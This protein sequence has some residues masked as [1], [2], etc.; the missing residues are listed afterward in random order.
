MEEE[1]FQSQRYRKSLKQKF[2][3]EGFDGFADEEVLELMLIYSI[4][5]C[6]IRPLAKSLLRVFGDFMGVLDAPMKELVAFP[7]MD[8]HTAIMLKAA[9][10]FP[11]FYS[12]VLEKERV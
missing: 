11:E 9:Q 10:V 5:G 12:K 3:K 6:D 4:P 7:G 2:I 1:S 8:L